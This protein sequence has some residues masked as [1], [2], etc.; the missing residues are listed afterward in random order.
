MI[1]VLMIHTRF[2]SWPLDRKVVAAS[3]ELD[4]QYAVAIEKRM[5]EVTAANQ[6]SCLEAFREAL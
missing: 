2:P 5:R 3:V 6:P 4:D 1:P